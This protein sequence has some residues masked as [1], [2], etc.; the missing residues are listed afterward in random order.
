MEGILAGIAVCFRS[1]SEASCIT[2]VPQT[3]IQLN[4][5]LQHT[6]LKQTRNGDFVTSTRSSCPFRKRSLPFL[7]NFLTCY[8]ECFYQNER[9]SKPMVKPGLQTC[10]LP[11]V[12]SIVNND[13]DRLLKGNSRW[14]TLDWQYFSWAVSRLPCTLLSS[15]WYL[16]RL[17]HESKYSSWRGLAGNQLSFCSFFIP[18]G[19]LISIGSLDIRAII[20]LA[21]ACRTV[22]KI[23]IL[24]YQLHNNIYFITIIF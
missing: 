23:F 15:H 7:Q 17:S 20:L 2:T 5:A 4:G 19:K 6:T 14:R 3:A 21:F 11:M 16:A 18:S 10:I 24:L 12:A 13:N 8:W 22:K 1:S 9:K